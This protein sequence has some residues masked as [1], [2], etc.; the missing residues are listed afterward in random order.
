MMV[1]LGSVQNEENINNINNKDWPK[2][3]LF[4]VHRIQGLASGNLSTGI[5]YRNLGKSV[6]FHYAQNIGI[7]AKAFCFIVHKISEPRQKRFVSL[8]IKYRNLGKSVLFHYAQNIGISAK[9]FRFIVYRNLYSAKAFCFIVYRILGDG[10]KY[11]QNPIHNEVK[12]KHYFSI[13]NIAY[14]SLLFIPN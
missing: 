3:V 4:I 8:C 14:F 9:A 12:P 2:P 1:T 13:H 10:E 7:S 11:L 5:K 6:L